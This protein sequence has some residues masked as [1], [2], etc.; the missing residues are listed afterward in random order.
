VTNWRTF[1]EDQAALIE[2]L[3]LDGLVGIAHSMGG[4]GMIDAAAI[5]GRFSRLL[6]LDPTEGVRTLNSNKL[7]F[8]I[9]FIPY[10]L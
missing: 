10:L 4:H 7:L 1:G 9:V 3:G 2:A 6:L 8:Y 5:G